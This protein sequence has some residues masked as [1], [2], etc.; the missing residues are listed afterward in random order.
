VV[1]DAQGHAIGDLKLADFKILDQGKPRNIVGFTLQQ[2]AP[3]ANR[4]QPA[5]PGPSTQPAHASPVYRRRNHAPRGAQRIIVF[6]FDDRHL[7]VGDLEQVKKAAVQMLDEPLP[8]APGNGAVVS[9][10]QLRVDAQ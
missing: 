10:R 2:G 3:L 6:L 5:S 8:M 4:E 9:G 7:G 1:R